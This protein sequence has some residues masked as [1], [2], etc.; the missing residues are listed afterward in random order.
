MAMQMRIMPK[1]SHFS[2]HA[3]IFYSLWRFGFGFFLCV[4]CFVLYLHLD[5]IMSFY[6]SLVFSEFINLLPPQLPASLL[7]LL[8]VPESPLLSL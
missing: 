5:Y 3:E 1:P 4:F 7:H 8:S 6:I 2:L